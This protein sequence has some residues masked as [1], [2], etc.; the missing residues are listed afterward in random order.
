MINTHNLTITFGKYSGERWTRLPI[1][2]LRWLAN[3]AA[4]EAKEI[5]AAE[6]ARR[7]TTIPST[8]ELSGH[9]ID[10][11]SQI[12]NR[13]WKKDG[14][15]SWLLRIA[16]EALANA[17]KNKKREII[18]HEGFKF[19]F[20]FGEYYPTLKTVMIDKKHK[21]TQDYDTGTIDC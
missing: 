7:G 1:S 20:S 16:E 14:V 9:S 4:G 17:P 12:A 13:S 3:S 15:Y 2:Y 21:K 6:I 5:A 19:V 11:A 18:F 10:R 8:V